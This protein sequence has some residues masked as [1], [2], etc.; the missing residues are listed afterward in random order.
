MLCK[1]GERLV[2]DGE[3]VL[4]ELPGRILVQDFGQFFH[5]IVDQTVQQVLG[6]LVMQ[7]KSPAVD[8]GQA[9]DLGDGDLLGGMGAQQF[10]I[11]PA[12]ALL[13]FLYPEIGL[14]VRHDTL[15]LT[16]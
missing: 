13:C 3:G 14:F 1:V 8:A 9:A 16:R 5:Q 7:V 12:D 11:G 6:I 15:L 10:Q 4:V 2:N